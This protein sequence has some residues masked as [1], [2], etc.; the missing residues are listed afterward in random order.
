[1]CYLG[2]LYD[3]L[4]KMQFIL[5]HKKIT[6][7]APNHRSDVSNELKHISNPLNFK[8][9]AFYFYTRT[10]TWESQCLLNLNF[11]IRTKCFEKC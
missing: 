11:I 5:L 4:L 8:V 10:S 2:Q 9:C 1:M 7:S 3:I 6:K